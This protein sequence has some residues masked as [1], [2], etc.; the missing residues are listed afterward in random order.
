[1]CECLPPS[2]LVVIV[3]DCTA[4]CVF[5]F[6]SRQTLNEWAC[7]SPC[8]FLGFLFY[9]LEVIIMIYLQSPPPL[10]VFQLCGQFTQTS[11][12]TCGFHVLRPIVNQ[13]R[14]HP[15]LKRAERVNVKTCPMSFR[16]QPQCQY[17]HSL[18]SCSDGGQRGGGTYTNPNPWRTY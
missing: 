7:I 10:F 2:L 14:M 9:F 11:P 8:H 5:T 12:S 1:M 15:F 4:G 3:E 18:C 16:I 13:M 6:T 17:P